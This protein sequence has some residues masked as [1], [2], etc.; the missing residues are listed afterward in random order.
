MQVSVE[1]TGA[2][3]R[4]ITVEIPWNVYLTK[5]ED[6]LKKYQQKAKIPGF[7]PGKAPL[8]MVKRSM[9]DL[10]N[11]IVYDLMR[12]HI[13]N[14][15]DNHNKTEGKDKLA[16][17][18]APHFQLPIIEEGKPLSLTA[19]FEVFPTIKLNTL[20]GVEVAKPT[21]TVGDKDI[22]ETINKL[23]TQL[24]EWVE[25]SRPAADGDRVELDFEG[26]VNDEP[27]AGNAA[28]Q[29]HL[30][31]GS[32]RMIPGFEEA[33]VGIKAGEERT[34]E[35]TFPA[36]YHA[37]ELAGKPAKFKIHAHKVEEPKLPEIDAKFAE[38]FGIEGGDL[39][40]MRK[41][42]RQ[43][44][45]RELDIALNN[46]LKQVVFDKLLELNPIEVP[47]AL[48]AEEI[49]SMRKQAE[50]NFRTKIDT[51]RAQTL[52]QEGAKRR[53][54]LQ[55]LVGEIIRTHEIKPDAERVKAIIQQRAA[56][57]EKPEELINLY[58][59]H[60]HLLDEIENLSLEE[61]VIDKLLADAKVVDKATSFAE[62]MNSNQGQ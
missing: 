41:E 6:E 61:Q 38:M 40:A 44:M 16:L 48:V 47:K 20:T 62:V 55:L 42:L 12:E 27:F 31:L 13:W 25:V 2:L 4:R 17:A 7:R 15:I 33:I 60:K 5:E 30:E 54:M 58:Y 22:D 34:I 51:T 19:V 37:T 36:E 18:S 10:R 56:A 45:E 57:Y 3:E 8:D 24:R 35:V 9:P 50:Q 32:K 26:F 46:K 52:F 43:G 1:A 23:R 14:A 53:V 49:E 39:E 59:Q 28:K 29:F 11:N 21:S